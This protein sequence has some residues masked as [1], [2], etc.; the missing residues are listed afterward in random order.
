MLPEANTPRQEGKYPT[1]KV[2]Q[3]CILKLLLHSVNSKPILYRIGNMQSAIL[4]SF[5]ATS[6]LPPCGLQS[7]HS[8]VPCYSRPY[9]VHSMSNKFQNKISKKKT[10]GAICRRT[11]EPCSQNANEG[12]YEISAV[13]IF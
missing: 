1:M 6:F 9:I 12:L 3:S 2:L 11:Q 10:N 5:V 13:F 8:R 7:I 4:R